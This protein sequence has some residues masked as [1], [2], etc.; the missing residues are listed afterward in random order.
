LWAIGNLS[1]AWI[2]LLMRAGAMVFLLPQTDGS[3]PGPIWRMCS[4]SF[5]RGSEHTCPAHANSIGLD[6]L[7]V[8]FL[9]LLVS[10]DAHLCVCRWIPFLQ[11]GR[12]VPGHVVRGVPPHP[13]SLGR[14][15]WGWASSSP[16]PEG[17]PLHVRTSTR[18]PF[19]TARPSQVRPSRLHD[20]TQAPS[21]RGSQP[22]V[23]AKESRVVGRARV[24]RDEHE[25]PG[26]LDAREK[27]RNE[28]RAWES[29]R[30]K[31]NGA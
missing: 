30:E 12:G 17:N 9:V 24:D 29:N 5:C 7:S 21:R 1:L 11:A 8:L 16:F 2:D 19:H 14:P 20:R 23:G 3:H 4:L 31:K 27:K 10:F 28:P 26:S 6:C 18:S 22:V 25:G 13:S 15:S